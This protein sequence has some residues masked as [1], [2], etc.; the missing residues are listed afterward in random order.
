M[1]NVIINFRRHLKRRNFSAHSVK[2]YLT[3]LKLFV[4]WLDVPLEQ[5]TAKKIDSYIDYLYQK[6]LQP[7]SINLY[8]AIIR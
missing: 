2:Y 3:I 5:V 6:R 7:A 1:T 4:L 8:L